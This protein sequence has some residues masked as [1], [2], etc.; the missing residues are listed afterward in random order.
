MGDEKKKHDPL[1]LL[2]GSDD[3]VDVDEA[4]AAAAKGQVVCPACGDWLPLELHEF[5]CA[6]KGHHYAVSRS[7]VYPEGPADRVLRRE[8]E[9]DERMQKL[10]K[11]ISD[12]VFALFI[13]SFIALLVV[14]LLWSGR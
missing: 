6:G 14:T 13:V 9:H 11:L 12:V 5:R 7:S 3:S 2:K 10:P 4:Q 1:T 8:R